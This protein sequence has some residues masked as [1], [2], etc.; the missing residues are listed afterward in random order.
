M[1]NASNFFERFHEFGLDS[2]ETL[3]I[4]S[5]TLVEK[6]VSCKLTRFFFSSNFSLRVTCSSLQLETLKW[7]DGKTNAQ[8]D[9][10]V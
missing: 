9:E 6:I 2:L 3:S 5:F 1:V 4:I 8:I 10:G 7:Q